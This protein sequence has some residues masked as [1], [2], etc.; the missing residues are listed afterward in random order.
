M[1]ADAVRQRVLAFAA[2]GLALARRERGEEIVERRVAGVLPV[3]LLV[4]AL[5]ESEFAE[6]AEFR[7]GRKG[8]V[9]AGCVVD[10]AELEKTGGESPAAVLG[11]RA[12]PHQ[13]PSSRSPA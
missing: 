11:M 12:G 8:D 6:K 13:Q 10:P 9:N 4:V 2:D 3:E 7:L 1:H 5:Q